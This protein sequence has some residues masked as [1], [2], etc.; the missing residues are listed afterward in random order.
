MKRNTEQNIVNA[1]VIFLSVKTPKKKRPEIV[2]VCGREW[3][4]FDKVTL[5]HL[6]RLPYVS[7]DKLIGE[8]TDGTHCLNSKCQFNRTTFESYADYHKEPA[9]S[10]EKLLKKWP[11]TL[12]AMSGFVEAAR[13]CKDAY[14]NDPAK[15]HFFYIENGNIVKPQLN[16]CERKLD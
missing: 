4:P 9:E 3:M 7:I 11:K 10:K 16:R 15:T 1:P 5:R 6:F 13:K 14:E 12:K 2:F 8:C